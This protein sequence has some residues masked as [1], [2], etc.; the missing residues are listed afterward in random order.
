[1]VGMVNI[2]KMNAIY[3]NIISIASFVFAL[4][5]IGLQMAKHLKKCTMA[6]SI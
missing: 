3:H 1:M 5:I 6:T 2:D 4:Q